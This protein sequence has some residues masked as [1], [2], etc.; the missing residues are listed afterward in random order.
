MLNGARVLVVEDETII[1][2]TVADALADQGAEVVGPA[3]SVRE[4][5]QIIR[6]VALD[7]ALLD[8]NVADGEITPVAESLIAQGV[9][10]LLYTGRGVPVALRSAYPEVPVLLKPVRLELLCRTIAGLIWGTPGVHIAPATP[11]SLFAKRNDEM[12]S[13]GH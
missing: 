8:V 11:A 1:A 5:F 4:A 6:G 10:L 3:A 9:P 7:A 12:Q 13:G 2:L